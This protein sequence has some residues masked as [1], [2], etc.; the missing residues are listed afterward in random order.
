ME[1][2]IGYYD[3]NEGP[4]PMTF[5][6]QA[7]Q[8][9][10]KILTDRI[11][12]QSYWTFAQLQRKLGISNNDWKR[13]LAMCPEGTFIKDSKTDKMHLKRD[14]YDIFVENWEMLLSNPTKYGGTLQ[15]YTSAK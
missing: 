5:M 2:S 10:H 11:L 8:W 7:L 3:C 9:E 1:D 12:S 14:W 13:L 15:A 6:A 4:S